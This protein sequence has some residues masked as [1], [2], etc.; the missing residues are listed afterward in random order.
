[1][2]KLF[3]IVLSIMIVTAA[4]AQIKGGGHY[5][6]GGRYY[7]PHTRVVVGLGAGYYSPYYFPFYSP[8][9]GYWRP[10]RLE[11][12]IEDIQADYKDKIY[13]VRH[14]KSIS[15]SERKAM[16]HQLKSDR[17]LAIHD[18]QRSYYKS[19]ENSPGVSREQ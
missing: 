9:D 8:Y 3:V 4:S 18:A 16:I 10:S 5:W 13:S 19:Y 11:L 6:T 14:D 7:H 15:K 2:K 12:K 1:M 17:E